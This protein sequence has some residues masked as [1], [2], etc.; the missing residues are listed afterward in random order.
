VK[1]GEPGG[2]QF[3]VF[4]SSEIL[5]SEAW[6]QLEK[7]AAVFLTSE[8]LEAEKYAMSDRLDH[9]FVV[10]QSSGKPVGIAVFHLITVQTKE[11]VE[12]LRKRFG[13]L[14]KAVTALSGGGKNFDFR[15][16]I[17]GSP[18]TTGELGFSFSEVIP[19]ALQIG[20]IRSAAKLLRQLEKKNISAVLMKD[21]YDENDKSAEALEKDG[22]TPFSVEPNMVLPI[23]PEWQSLNDYLN[24]LRSKY[25]TKAN[26]ALRRSEK[27]E[28]RKLTAD[29]VME[30]HDRIEELYSQVLSRASF[31]IGSYN[32]KM[33]QRLL[34]KL[35]DNYR[36]Y[37]YFI[38]GELIA[39]QTLWLHTDDLE[40][41]FV[42]IDYSKNFELAV[43]QRMLYE[44]IRV[45]IEEKKSQVVFG[46]SAMEIKSTVGAVSIEAS[47]YIRHKSAALNPFLSFIFKHVSPSDFRGHRAFLENETARIDAAL[48]TYL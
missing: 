8:Y 34:E 12:R 30:F 1:T 11:A 29:E 18:F 38:D 23:F 31:S 4:D 7:E 2:L 22:F 15:L 47:C 43:Y 13:V 44:Y 20:A 6:K 36:I 45:A 19:R 48:K 32:C 9:R 3:S 40:A 26:A 27:I 16:L 17:N 14:D 5:H 24:S 42:G 46:R 10:F 28:I 33:F 39:F 37:G 25:R 35:P 21:F 41:H